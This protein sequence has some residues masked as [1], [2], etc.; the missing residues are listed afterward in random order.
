MLLE[1][2]YEPFGA[3]ALFIIDLPSKRLLLHFSCD[4][5]CEC[6]HHLAWEPTADAVVA[7]VPVRGKPPRPEARRYRAET[8]P[9]LHQFLEDGAVVAPAIGDDEAKGVP[10]LLP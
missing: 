5:A 1:P 9:L 2:G 4:L 8:L 3:V 7:V 10:P 6:T